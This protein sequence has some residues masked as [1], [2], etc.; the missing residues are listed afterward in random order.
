[1]K[2]IEIVGGAMVSAAI[3]G[4]GCQV[5]GTGAMAVAS[6]DALTMPR[7]IVDPAKSVTDHFYAFMDFGNCHDTYGRS[8]VTRKN[9]AKAKKALEECWNRFSPEI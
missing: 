4:A 6:V 3:F 1:M 5:V 8:E 2:L 9:K 7:H